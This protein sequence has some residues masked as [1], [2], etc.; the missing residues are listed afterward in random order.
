MVPEVEGPEPLQEKE[1]TVAKPVE[2]KFLVQL[3]LMFKRTPR[4]LCSCTMSTIS[5]L[6]RQVAGG[7]LT[8]QLNFY[9]VIEI[10]CTLNNHL[11]HVAHNI[12]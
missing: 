2:S 1:P 5:P 9:D 10:L 3:S 11:P 12:S 6:I 4:Y 8:L 7:R